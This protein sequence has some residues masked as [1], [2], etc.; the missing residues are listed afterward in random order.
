MKKKLSTHFS[1]NILIYSVLLVGLILRLFYLWEYSLLPDWSQLTVDNNFHHHWA[2]SIVDGNILGDTTYFRAP[3][4]IFY[5]A[6]IYKLFGISLWAVRLFSIIPGLLSIYMTYITGKKVYNKQT[7]L[8]AGFIHAIFPIIYYFESELLLDSFFMLLLQ[9]G[10]YFFI[11]WWKDGIFQS[12]FLSGI[13][14][15]L[16][17]ITRPTALVIALFIFLI[18]LI[19]QKIK[20]KAIVLFTIGLVICIAPIFIRNIVIADDPVLIAS[21]GGINLY[22]G[23]NDAADGISAVLPQPLGFNWH[24]KQ[25]THQ[26]E[27]E[28]NKKLSQGEISSF[29]MSKAFNWIKDNPKRFMQLY[30]EKLYHSI[31]NREISNNRYLT[32]FFDKVISLKYNYLSFGIL[33]SLTILSLILTGSQNKQALFL[34]GTIVLYIL[35]TSLFFF[36]S[37]FRL[38]LIPFYIILSSYA[39]T[40]IRILLKENRKMGLKVIGITIVV[41]LISFYPVISVPLGTAS[42]LYSAKGLYYSSIDDQTRAL[43]FFKKANEADPSYPENNLNIGATFIKIGMIDSARYYINKEKY[44]HPLHSKGFV[45]SASIY[46]NLNLYDSAFVEINKSLELEPFQITA[47]QLYTRILF[48]LNYSFFDIQR[49][50]IKIRKRTD[51][52][53]Y[54]L[55]EIAS[56]IYNDSTINNSLAVSILKDAIKTS[57]PPIEIDDGS[58]AHKSPNRITMWNNQRAKSYYHLGFING[59]SGQFNE[60]I[61][62]SN[63]A[64]A[65]DSSLAEAYVN[66]ISGY[67][68]SNQIQDGQRVL[69]LAIQRFPNHSNLL[70]IQ[71]ILNQ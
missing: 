56:L 63:K 35:I 55:N 39:L 3:F 27:K 8:V 16:A 4:Y 26:A 21:Q 47:N 44:L 29:W 58:F 7:G 40:S 54:L 61:I 22:V 20:I 53:I 66:L 43:A 51:N 2:L 37:R 48:K 13:F 10:I 14:L 30:L 32:Q 68:S 62:N 36:S 65:I 59:I 67:L 49:E 19:M 5:L 34:V 18:I 15:G 23:N 71:N 69:Q 6:G 25:I 64:I 9:I 31:S 11:K 12:I 28:S 46:Y 42:H 57:P 50:I 52:N 33:F 60:A 38:P 45:N 41:G 17:S 70:Q 1:Q 24:I